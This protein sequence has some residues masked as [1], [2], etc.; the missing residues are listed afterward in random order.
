MPPILSLCGS[1]PIN[2]TGLP[3]TAPG[4]SNRQTSHRCFS[5]FQV[6]FQ[7]P[8]NHITKDLCLQS[9][10][11]L[12]FFFS[13]PD[14]LLPVTLLTSKCRTINFPDFLLIRSSFTVELLRNG[15]FAAN[16]CSTSTLLCSLPSNNSSIWCILH[17]FG[18]PSRT[19]TAVNNV[20][21]NIQSLW[22]RS[23]KLFLRK[24]LHRHADIAEERREEMPHKVTGIQKHFNFHME[25]TG[26]KMC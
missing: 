22:H 25:I 23:C 5:H 14:H 19:D 2:N 10:S 18:S 7:A 11:E 3:Q 1:H 6:F 12:S 4:C 21:V 24:T 8:L 17:M 26:N 15:A 13:W 16:Q 9:V 20:A